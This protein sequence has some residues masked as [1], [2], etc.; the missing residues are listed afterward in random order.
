MIESAK[1]K[2]KVSKKTKRSWRK[3][4]DTKDVDSFLE[5]S[6]LEE[7]L[8]V[9]FAERSDKDLFVVDAQPEQL[10]EAVKTKREH[11]LALRNA[12]PRCYASLKP[13]TSVPDPISK[14]NRVKTPEERKNPITRRLEQ[15]RKISGHLKLREKAALKDKAIAAERRSARPKRGEY[16]VDIWDQEKKVLPLVDD[17][18]LTSDTVRHTLA[19]RGIRKKK[20]P[21]SVH[22]KTSILPAVDVP[23]PGTSYN[24]S[25]EDHQELLRDV[26]QQ[27][28]KL[29]KE[30]AHLNRVT[31]KMFKKVSAEQKNK[32]WLRESSE[33]LPLKPGKKKSKT[34]TA[35][36]DDEDS[37][38]KSVN[39][40]A[41]NAKKTL[42]QRRKQKEQRQLALKVKHAK[43]EK[44]KVSDIYKLK[45]LKKHLAKK[46]AKVEML[47]KLREKAKERKALEPKTLNKHKF[48]PLETAFK[49]GEELTGNLRNT[50]P[51]GSL[52]KDR[53]KSMQQR[54]ILAPAT[55]VL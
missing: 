18:W 23:H 17:Q 7:R 55:R 44:K 35:D 33:G 15:E 22:K 31:T 26:A 30:E 53:Y 52:L 3:H 28:L 4:V 50:D 1:K 21:A 27:E 34:E 37:T 5:S 16:K 47:R 54:S 42:V 43:I 48:E 39:P 6:R 14:R 13:H 8:G 24:P 51:A 10:S 20:V 11:R 9:P 25:Y 40:P 49:L 29:M 19:N 38:V 36:D 32:D 12:E 46:E 2:R 45:A 41:K